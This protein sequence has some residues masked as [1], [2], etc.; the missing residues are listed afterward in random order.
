MIKFLA[1]DVFPGVLARANV[2]RLRGQVAFPLHWHDFPEVFWVSEGTGM[3]QINGQEHALGPGS[4]MSVTPEA[5]RWCG[6]V[7]GFVP[8]PTT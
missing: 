3:H 7:G 6:R 8:K 4:L 5:A 2:S 1:K